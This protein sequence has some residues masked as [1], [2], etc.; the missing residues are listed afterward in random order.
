MNDHNSMS[1]PSE[2]DQQATTDASRLISQAATCAEKHGDLFGDGLTARKVRERY[3]VVEAEPDAVV[4]DVERHRSIGGETYRSG[5]P[6][7]AYETYWTRYRYDAAEETLNRLGD[8]RDGKR[9]VDIN[10]YGLASRWFDDV[11]ARIDYNEDGDAVL[12]E[13]MNN[14]ERVVDSEKQAV[15]ALTALCDE[16]NVRAALEPVLSGACSDDE[17]ENIL[18]E[19]RADLRGRA[20][21]EARQAWSQWKNK[22]QA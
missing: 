1:P 11:S 16:W 6:M 19:L 4:F 12:V 21:E 10:T 8:G 7:S 17:I 14:F 20:A 18:E 9:T 22:Q 13:S 5:Q 3:T 15:E 2:N